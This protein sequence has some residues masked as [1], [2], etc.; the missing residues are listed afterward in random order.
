M[1]SSMAPMGAPLAGWGARHCKAW[2]RHGMLRHFDCPSMAARLRRGLDGH[3]I[4]RS[5]LSHQG[6]APRWDG[7]GCPGRWC[8]PG[9]AG[10]RGQGDECILPPSLGWLLRG[11]GGC[12]QAG[13]CSLATV[14]LPGSTQRGLVLG[15]TGRNDA[16]IC[17][18]PR[19]GGGA[20]V[21]RGVGHGVG[22]RAPAEGEST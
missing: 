8:G 7:L 14:W 9:A 5:P 12:W 20:G 4:G 21:G 10:R 19:G 22:G 18:R 15:G 13:G 16:H 17:K 6:L 1:V 11:R 3:C 2:Q